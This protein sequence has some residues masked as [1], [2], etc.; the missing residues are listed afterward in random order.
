MK[1]E[2]N[3][4]MECVK[5]SQSEIKL[6]MR[7]SGS[8]IFAQRDSHINRLDHVEG[9]LSGIEDRVEKLDNS[10]KENV[11]SIKTH[12]YNIQEL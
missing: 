9:R 1:I 2:F 8:Q 11:N 6:K 3:K 5:K 7:I 4:E 12:N 10:V